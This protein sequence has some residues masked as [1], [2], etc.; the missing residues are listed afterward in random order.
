[1]V[2]PRRQ[3]VLSFVFSGPIVG[4]FLSLMLAVWRRGND[5]DDATVGIS[6]LCHGLL[7]VSLAYGGVAIIAPALRREVPATPVDFYNGNYHV[8]GPLSVT[9]GLVILLCFAAP[10][11]ARDPDFARQHPFTPGIV[12]LAVTW[13]ACG[14]LAPRHLPQACARLLGEASNV[15][16][17][18]D[19]SRIEP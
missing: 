10:L 2:P 1:M 13:I 14:L 18:R 9:C 6:S 17:M 4:V 19:Q 15:R 5:L 3:W 12:S 8:A 7:S 16:Q 11:Y